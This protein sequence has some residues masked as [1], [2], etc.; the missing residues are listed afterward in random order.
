MAHVLIGFAEALP[1][2]EV[3]FSLRNAGHRVSAFA[4]SL[5]IPLSRLLD[6]ALH[7]LPDPADGTAPAVAGLQGLMHGADAPDIVLPLDDGGL[8]LVDAVLG[9]D[10]RNAGASGDQARI[11]LDKERQ[12]AAARDAG[13][14]VPDTVIVRTAAD[15]DRIAHFPAIAKPSLALCDYDG[16]LGK[17]DA[18][19]LAGHADVATLRAQMGETPEPLLVQPLIAGVGEGVFGHATSDGVIAWSGHR[20]VRMMNPHGS[21]SSACVSLMPDATL[22][23]AVQAFL[24]GIGW[25][26]PFMIELLRDSDGIPWFM[27]LNGRMWGSLALARRQG[28]EYPA[29]SVAVA[30]D[31]TFRPVA[32]PAPKRPVVQ[33]HLGRDLLHLAF[34]LRG[35]K[36][37]FHRT[38]WPRFWRSAAGVFAPAGPR[39]FY[40]YDPAHGKY[41]IWDALWTIRKTLKR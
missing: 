12:V 41:F 10:P 15:L 9:D 8:W 31:P 17:S 39:A 30:S 6:G 24:D 23:A 13:L 14:A 29:W 5:D 18:T 26:G 7:V 37:A 2:P 34:V 1:A 25:R 38:G 11:A 28:L 16:R 19:Y 32:P 22:R 33:R 36:S 3:V 40:N 4:R 21:G 35:P 27:E 20:R